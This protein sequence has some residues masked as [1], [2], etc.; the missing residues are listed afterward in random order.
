VLSAG[1]RVLR[2]DRHEPSDATRLG[3]AGTLLFG[4]Q[5]QNARQWDLVRR[6]RDAKVDRLQLS[7]RRLWLRGRPDTFQQEYLLLGLPDVC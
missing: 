6:L 7:Q 3:H 1:Q 5:V 4:R 2:K